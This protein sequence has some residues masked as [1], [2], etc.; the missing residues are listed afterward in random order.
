MLD[1]SLYSRFR[2]RLFATHSA[3]SPTVATPARLLTRLRRIQVL[4]LHRSSPPF[5]LVRA[6]DRNGQAAGFLAK[7]DVHQIQPQGKSTMIAKLLVPALAGAL[8]CG[9]AAAQSA[10]EVHD[11]H[12]NDHLEEI[13]KRIGDD[14]TVNGNLK[15]LT[16]LGSAKNSGDDAKEPEEKLNE[17]TPSSQVD[18]TVEDRCPNPGAT[19]GAAQQ[20]WQLCQDIAKTELAQ[21]KYSMAMY[22]LA[23][24]RQKRLKEIENERSNLGGE[25]Q[26]KLQDNNNKLLALLS[27]MEVD[28]QQRSA[29]MDAYSARLTYLRS[30]RDMLSHEVLRGKDGG[31]AGAGG[32]GVSGGG[33][34]AAGL[35]GILLMK[36][37]LESLKSP[38]RESGWR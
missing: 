30:V 25:D 2:I 3:I 15:K 22:K 24:E 32:G 7:P 38:R 21:Y 17:Q 28:Q 11:Q 33:K 6:N 36:A 35:A 20:Q 1:I 29:Y 23:L 34:A 9:P 19:S 31:S 4:A 8:I 18:K 27:R 5:A 12:A 26:G 10:W 13:E 37:T 14:G 16:K